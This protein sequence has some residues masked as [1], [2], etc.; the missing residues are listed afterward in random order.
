M[1]TEIPL[2]CECGAVTGIA[3]LDP[4]G[5]HLVCMCRY[6]QGFAKYLA[7]EDTILDHNGG[8]DIYQ[9]TPSQIH[10]STGI[11]QLRCVQ[12]S[13]KGPLRWYTDCCKTPVGNTLAAKLPFV[14]VPTA[15]IDH[16]TDE[17]GHDP[18]GPVR[19]RI[20]AQ[21]AIG[22]VDNGHQTAPLLLFARA[23]I[24]MLV[25]SI[26]GMNQPSPF[27]DAKSGNPATQPTTLDRQEKT[28]LGLPAD[29]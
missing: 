25:H 9:L 6:C 16:D 14:G 28:A 10:I 21:D 4:P 29:P 18:L 3:D 2:K 8:T 26:H 11:E 20:Y 15:F 22:N 24:K 7:R 12:L 19:F 1:S 13:A 5:N 17:H 27:Y 23:A